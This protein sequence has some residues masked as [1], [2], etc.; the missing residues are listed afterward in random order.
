MKTARSIGDVGEDIAEKYLKKHG[1]RIITRNFS[2]RGGEIDIIAYRFGVLAYVEVKT[3]TNEAFGRP[4]DAVDEEKIAHINR[5]KARF[6]EL[7][8]RGKKLA[9]F[10]PFGLEIRRKI[11]KERIDVIEIY[12]SKSHEVQKINHIKDW[13]CL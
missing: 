10:Y 1:Y 6:S 13:K 12:L 4:I 5:A 8:V 7:Y 9:V 3:R 2:V 11:F